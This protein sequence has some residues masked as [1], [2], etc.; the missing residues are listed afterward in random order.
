MFDR[1]YDLQS[2]IYS[3]AL[4]RYLA[5]RVPGYRY[6]EHFGGSFYLFLRGMRPLSGPDN[7]VYFERVGEETIAALEAEFNYSG[8]SF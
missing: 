1:R 5:S 6:E 2:L 8:S 3:I 7:G 4:H